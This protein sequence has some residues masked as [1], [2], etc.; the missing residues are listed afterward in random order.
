ME[1]FLTQSLAFGACHYDHD[2]R[3]L[4]HHRV[5]D[6]AEIRFRRDYSV[7]FIPRNGTKI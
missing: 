1:H 7:Q 3:T 4:A 2:A 5:Y 6:L